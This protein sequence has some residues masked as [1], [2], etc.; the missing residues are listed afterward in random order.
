MLTASIE[1]MVTAGKQS[2]RH[3]P[4]VRS[5]GQDYFFFFRHFLFFKIRQGDASLQDLHT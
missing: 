2:G 1:K 4:A 5:I 3:I